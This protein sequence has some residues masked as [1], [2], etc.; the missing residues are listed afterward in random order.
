MRRR[1][2]HLEVLGIDVDGEG[3]EAQDA[4]V[5]GSRS[6]WLRPCNATRCSPQVVELMLAKGTGRLRVAVDGL[7]A[8]GKTSFSHESAERI[9]GW[10]RTVLRAG[11]DDF[12]RPWKDRHRYDRDSG[13]G[14]YRNAYDYAA[15]RRLLLEPAGAGGS[16]R[17]ALCSID[18]LSQVH[19]AQEIT[20][21]P[22]IWLDVPAD[23]SLRRAIERDGDDAAMLHRDRYLA[24]ELLYLAEI[25]PV[26]VADVVIVNSAF[27]APRILRGPHHG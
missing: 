2:H 18:P 19:H 11:L 8:A 26:R 1:S 9:S 4:G 24:S 14:Y 7:T 13:E 27:D 21:A 12:K 15:V 5:G 23:L 20:V 6:P 17:C 3:V 16:G 22:V 10:G 25:D